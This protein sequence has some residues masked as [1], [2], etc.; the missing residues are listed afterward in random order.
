ME[1][2]GAVYLRVIAFRKIS[3]S[4]F[5][6][7]I[8]SHLMFLTCDL[9]SF[10]L[11]EI[12]RIKRQVKK[13]GWRKDKFTQFHL[14]K[15]FWRRGDLYQKV[16]IQF[17]KKMIWKKVFSYK[18]VF[19]PSLPLFMDDFV[20]NLL[21]NCNCNYILFTELPW[22]GDSKETFRSS[23]QLPPVRNTRRRLHTVPLIAER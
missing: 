12:T 7:V 18:K 8:V 3:Q 16:F 17:C 4:L 5:I 14:G 9:M 11:M 22:P 21:K 1:R 20:G 19:S 2:I 13:R 23:S 10:V 6:D 15:Q